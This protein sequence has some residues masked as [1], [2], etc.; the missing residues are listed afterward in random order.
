[1]VRKCFLAFAGFIVAALLLSTVVANA[2]CIRVIDDD[3][4][5]VTLSG[6]YIKHYSRPLSK[7]EKQEGMFYW[8]G[9]YLK[10]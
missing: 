10:L 8:N 1:M 7:V 9:A 5:K 4:P 3:A 6:R 2:L